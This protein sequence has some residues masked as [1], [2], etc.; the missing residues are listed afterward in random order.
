MA[1]LNDIYMLAESIRRQ[2][3]DLPSRI[4][5]A[6]NQVAVRSLSEVS[7]NLGTVIAG[8]FRSGNGVLPGQGFTGLRIG[9]PPIPYDDKNWNLVV[10]D[11]DN[12]II[13]LSGDAG[14]FRLGNGQPIGGGYS[15]LRIAFPAVEYN[16]T[17][18][19][20][21]GI[22]NDRLTVGIR[23]SDG[24][25]VAAHGNVELNGFG[26]NF[27]N[28]YLLSTGD[29]QQLTWLNLDD[30]VAG[31]I[32]RYEGGNFQWEMTAN[33]TGGAVATTASWTMQGMAPR[34]GYDT[35]YYQICGLTRHQGDAL[36]ND[37]L[38]LK[39]HGTGP[40]VGTAGTSS[41]LALYP[42]RITINKPLVL[43]NINASSDIPYDNVYTSTGPYHAL[44]AKSA[45]L[46]EITPTSTG[47][48]DKQLAYSSDIPSSSDLVVTVDYPQNF[49]IFMNQF[50]TTPTIIETVYTS[51]PYNVYFITDSD[52]DGDSD[53]YSANILTSTG[54]WS[55]DALGIS[56]PS[57]GK[58]DM[59]LDDSVISSDAYDW[60]S[61]SITAARHQTVTGVSITKPGA[62]TLKLK[63]N[64]KNGSASEYR[65][66][67]T[68]VTGKRT[69]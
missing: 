18:W 68:C 42:T 8:E 14:E 57:L 24:V 51:Q 66:G 62:H 52:A 7:D 28:I 9:Y 11:R 29:P 26:I 39:S 20:L 63:I 38:Y 23:S 35:A 65:L 40:L 21:V 56:G 34:S 19:N 6:G 1:N 10:V 61:A 45:G 41:I 31:Y 50:N 44:I 49:K 60:Y 17:L 33:T 67:V 69:A 48:Y 22:D 27:R 13:G 53:E 64:G 30:S 2:V 58:T 4:S 32:R 3:E 55:F 15:G 47:G 46:F 54:T 5:I 16:G 12:L 43:F 36:D 59:L 25:L 37:Y